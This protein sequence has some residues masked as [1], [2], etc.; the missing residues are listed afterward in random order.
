MTGSHEVRGS[1]PLGSTN[2]INNL[3]RPSRT[4]FVVLCSY[5]VQTLETGIFIGGKC[6]QDVIRLFLSKRS[7]INPLTEVEFILFEC[8]TLFLLE[9]S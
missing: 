7:S 5:R 2:L 1:I 9:L 3:G 8:L 6:D 4:P